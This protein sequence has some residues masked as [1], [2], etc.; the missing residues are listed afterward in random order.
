MACLFMDGFDY[1]QTADMLNGIWTTI[2]QTVSVGPAG[3][4]QPSG[5]GAILSGGPTLR[6]TFGSNYTQGI[7][8]FAIKGTGASMASLSFACI[9]DGVTEQ[10]SIR[11]NA[12]SVLIV[13]RSGTTLATGTTTLSVGVWYYIE[14]KFTIATGTGGSVELH[15]NGATE[16]ASTSGLNTRSTAN[17]QWNGFHFITV[18]N[19]DD[20]YCLDTS[21]GSNT[22]F[23][24]PVRIAA[25]YTTAAGSHTDWTSNGGTNEGNVSE[26]FED[27]D[28]SFNQSSTANQVDSFPVQHLPAASGT[29]FAVKETVFAKYDGG[30]ARSVAP[31]QR[32]GGS[33]YPGTGQAPGASWAA[34]SQ[35][36]DTQPVA[37]SPAWDIA[38]VNGMEIGYK[39]LS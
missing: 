30:A 14:L 24:G 18:C 31:F 39:L 32:I 35:I 23:W 13:S 16:I 37:G 34:I 27:G 8:G 17:T 15:L 7:L 1:Y 3:A 9:I 2:V 25:L 6:K 38:T 4:R 33:D 10:I 12:S 28:G 5:Q 26:Q 11:T 20:L 29:V 36:Y 19:I 21:T 22:D